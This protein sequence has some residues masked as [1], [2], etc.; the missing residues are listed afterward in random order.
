MQK[1]RALS[2]RLFLRRKREQRRRLLGGVLI[3]LLFSLILLLLFHLADMALVT[4]EESISDW[5]LGNLLEALAAETAAPTVLPTA[6]EEEHTA[7]PEKDWQ[8]ILINPWN[9]IPA[10]YEISLKQLRNGHTV[11]ERCYDEL[12]QMMDACQNAGFS[13][14]ICSSYR[15]WEKQQQLFDQQVALYAQGRTPEDARK[16]AAK[17]VALPGTSEHQLGLAVDIV[18]ANYQSLDSSQENT[19]VQRW[20]MENSWRY[21][22]ILRYPSDKE[23]E[24]GI[25]YEPWHYRYV[26]KDAAAEIYGRGICLEEYLF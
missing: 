19:P 23:T 21:G 26:G 14:L 25:M 9:S 7:S 5:E 13:P 6:T 20:L 16:E 11:D 3:A 2:R 17:A 8:L 15:S 12:Q 18:D 4:K 10:G 24:T 22:F 1:S